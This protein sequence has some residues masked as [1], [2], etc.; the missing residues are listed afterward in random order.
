[1]E[2]QEGDDEDSGGFGTLVTR[3]AVFWGADHVQLSA[4]LWRRVGGRWIIVYVSSTC[5]G[6]E[7][8][9]LRCRSR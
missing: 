7:T 2:H 6:T 9:P 5:F 8:V 3:A 4:G 1:M